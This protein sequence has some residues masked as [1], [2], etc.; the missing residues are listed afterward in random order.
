MFLRSSTRWKHI[1]ELA[2]FLGLNGSSFPADSRVEHA[3]KSTKPLK[4]EI[5]AVFQ[6]IFVNL[7][8]DQQLLGEFHVIEGAT[9]PWSVW[10][11]FHGAT[12]SQSDISTLRA[13]GQRI[14]QQ[15]AYTMLLWVNMGLL[16][17]SCG[18]LTWVCI[19]RRKNCSSLHLT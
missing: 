15:N 14:H 7:T 2:T 1:D 10:D 17:L 19:H 13:E 16:A 4:P 5:A 3:R 9:E 6:K 18:L 12:A 11:V 8:A